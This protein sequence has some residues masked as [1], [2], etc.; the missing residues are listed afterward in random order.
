MKKT[1]LL[2]P[3]ALL[4]LAVAGQGYAGGS[5]GPVAA[6]DLHE[7]IGLPVYGRAYADLG[8]VSQVDTDAGVIGISGKYGE[9]AIVSTSM[10]AREGKRLRA[11]LL[12]VGDV[13][14]ASMMNLSQQGATLVAPQVIIRES[15]VN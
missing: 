2:A 8:T 15:R 10:L 3:M 12:T 9:F 4:F 14:F 6:G 1:M 7:F 11:P 13:K 5:V